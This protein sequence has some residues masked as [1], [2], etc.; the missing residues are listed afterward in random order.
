MVWSNN[1]GLGAA[2]E[3]EVFMT[4]PA[5]RVAAKKVMRKCVRIQ[6]SV[7]DDPLPVDCSDGH[8]CG[9]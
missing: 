7:F 3:F 6:P 4:Q 9:I 8:G 2:E 1:V 5:T